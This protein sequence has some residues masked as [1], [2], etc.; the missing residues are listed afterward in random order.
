[1]EQYM[2]AACIEYHRG[3][4]D[5]A[6][7]G[8]HVEYLFASMEEAFAPEHAARRGYTHLIGSAKRDPHV[9]E[10]LEKRVAV[11]YRA[12]L[13]AVMPDVHLGT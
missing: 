11:R 3:R 6:F 9:A 2:L 12:A 10:L 7:R 8:V 4:V 5:S 13:S 1:M